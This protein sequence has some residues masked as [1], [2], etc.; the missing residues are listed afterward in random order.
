MKS[1]ELPVLDL[2]HN[3]SVI[4]YIKI[5]VDGNLKKDYDE[6]PV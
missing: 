6:Y 2:I 5:P 3:T 1:E 4:D